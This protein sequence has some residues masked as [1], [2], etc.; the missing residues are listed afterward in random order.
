MT[1]KKIMKDTKMLGI[2]CLF[3]NNIVFDMDNQATHKK[4]DL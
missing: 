3:A 4:V 2:I 1:V